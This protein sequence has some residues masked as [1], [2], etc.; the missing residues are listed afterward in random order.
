MPMLFFHEIRLPLAKSHRYNIKIRSPAC[1]MAHGDPRCHGEEETC[2][3]GG[4][5]SAE[6]VKT[7][8]FPR[9][10]LK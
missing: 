6:R 5:V 9:L 10:R 4:G 2:V 7:L 8:A 3:P 1:R